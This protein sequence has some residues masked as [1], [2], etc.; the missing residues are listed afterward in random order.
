MLL[1][2]V[3]ICPTYNPGV[4][5]EQWIDE[6]KNQSVENLSILIIDSS[7]EDKSVS[8]SEEAGFDV[9]SIPKQEFNHAGT[10][11][12]AAQI[13]IKKLNP[14]VIVFLTQDALLNSPDS[15]KNILKPFEDDEIAA[16][17]G[18]QLPH[19]AADAVA[20]HS[21]M[22]NYKCESHENSQSHISEKG[23]KA[24]YMSNSFAAY[25]VSVFESL[26]GFPEGLIFGE[27]MY[28]AAK[29]ILAGHKTYYASA[30]TVRHSHNYSLK[31]EFNRYF[32]IGVF[33]SSQPFL[34]TNFG[35]PSGEGLRFAISE[36]KYCLRHG[37]VYWALNS[38]IRTGLKFLGY[39][40]G[41]LHL[42]LPKFMNKALSMDKNYWM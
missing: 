18:R 27:D 1:R 8:L 7:S 23:L 16:V 2:T 35:K 33:H 39:K 24:A 10:R 4:M 14:E 13:A 9:L 11:N 22:Y 3:L 41:S 42:G 34:L 37:G 36:L 32:D 5:W 30:A 19:V 29:M 21:R 38:I 40:L 6:V 28:L 17:C 26:G 15:I 31:E 20:S 25:R 12:K